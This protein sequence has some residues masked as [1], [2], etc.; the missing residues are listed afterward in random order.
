MFQ[1][2]LVMFDH[3][4]C[5][6]EHTP[7]S[8]LAG[9]IRGRLESNGWSG[10]A[11]VIVLAPELEVWV[12]SNSPHVEVCLGWANQQPPLSTWLREKGRWP[13]NAPKPPHPKEALVAALYQVR[14]PRSAAIYGQLARQVSL[15]GH[16]EPSFV[17]FVT[18][19]QR[20]FAQ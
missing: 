19:L 3:A 4:G 20:W 12:W 16:T 10:R 9:E 17:R 2:T 7:A 18:T 8:E 5:G 6:R 15:H 14:K 11:E 13:E 1:R